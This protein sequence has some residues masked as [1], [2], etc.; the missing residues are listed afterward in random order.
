MTTTQDYIDL[1][2]SSIVSGNANEA[3][4]L[5][6]RASLAYDD[7]IGAS[8][9]TG[10]SGPNPIL[11][12]KYKKEPAFD[13]RGKGTPE[14]LDKFLKDHL[15]PMKPVD[16]KPKRPKSISVSCPTCKAKPGKG[17]FVMTNKGPGAKPTTQLRDKK[18][19]YHKTRAE[20]AKAVQNNG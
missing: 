2:I 7:E 19:G 15:P 3:L 1:A 4:G 12:V 6:L 16:D 18:L 20:K 17:C 8:G 10:G 11:S 5:L 14:D 13:P 9:G